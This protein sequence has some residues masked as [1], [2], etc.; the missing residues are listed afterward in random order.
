MLLPS[1]RDWAEDSHLENGNY[2]NTCIECQRRFF[3]YKRRGVCKVC[4]DRW[5]ADNCNTAYQTLSSSE[6]AE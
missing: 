5:K 2:I 4:A 1:E 6:V 3:G